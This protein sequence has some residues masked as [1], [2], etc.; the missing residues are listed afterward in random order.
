VPAILARQ[1]NEAENKADTEYFGHSDDFGAAQ[2]RGISAKPKGL[3]PVYRS[4]RS[5]NR[6]RNRRLHHNNPSGPRP[7]QKIGYVRKLIAT[8]Q[9]N[10]LIVVCNSAIVIAF[11][12][13]WSIEFLSHE[14]ERPVSGGSVLRRSGCCP[15]RSRSSG[16]S[17]RSSAR[18]DGLP[19]AGSSVVLREVRGATARTNRSGRGGL[20]CG[21]PALA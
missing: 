6:C 4:R 8:L 13:R 21:R 2:R 20:H 1:D 7:P 12:S 11:D 3:E 10:C 5:D 18:Q 16:G 19:A 9:P 14:H 15:C 17:A